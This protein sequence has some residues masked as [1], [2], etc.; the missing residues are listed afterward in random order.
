MTSARLR[1]R[2]IVYE[3][4]GGDGAPI[5]F[6]HA[7][8]GS[9]AM[10]ERQIDAVRASGHR[11]IAYDRLGSGGST[12]DAGA[13]PGCA[14]D[15][16]QGLVEHL[17]IGHFH[18]VGTAA[19]GIVALDYAVTFQHHLRSLVVSNSI[20]GLLDEEYVALGE[21]L[22]PAPA[23]G[24]LPPEVRELGPSFRAIDEAGTAR[25]IELEHAS[26]PAHPLLSPQRTRNHLTFAVLETIHVP[27]LLLTGDGDLY[28]PPP[29]LRMFAARIA[30][31]Q[32]LVVP[33]TGHSAY[34]EQP[35][36]FNRAI[37]D[38]V[39]KR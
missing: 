31:A 5:V 35:E 29:V 13:D 2:S 37:L 19:G 25:W 12:L 1:D 33:E 6:L 3:D 38:F 18:L 14:A 28:C 36:I 30:G 23:F 11:F 27:T 7:A 8:S 10:W 24:T 16:L 15:D 9:S 21:R 17:G 22:R 4:T 32:T 26:R 20:G 39:A 34:W